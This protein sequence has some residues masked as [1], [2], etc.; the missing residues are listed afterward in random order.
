MLLLHMPQEAVLFK[1]FATAVPM[2]T[3]THIVCTANPVKLMKMGRNTLATK[4]MVA[5][6]RCIK[7]LTLEDPVRRVDCLYMPL[8][9]H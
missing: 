3:D 2:T 1:L 5:W 8:W 4:F 9:S 7:P 6:S